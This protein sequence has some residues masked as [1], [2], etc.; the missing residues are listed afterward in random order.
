MFIESIDSERLKQLEYASFPGKIQVIDGVGADFNR[1][2]AYLRSQ[3]VIGF[4]TETRPCFSANQPRYGV[5]LL[6]LSGPEKAFLFRVNKMGMHRRLC[7]IL[8]DEKIVKV[9]AAIHD[10]I[11]GLQKLNDFKAGGFV[12]L[13]RIVWEWGIRDKSVKKM[14]AIIMGFRISKTQQLSN[15]EAETL[16][17]QQCKYAATDAWVC[18]EMYLK[19][20]KSDKHPLELEEK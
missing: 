9:G 17:E 10:D 3:K 6:Q 11:R 19:L 2:V 7:S 14:A 13:Q 15:W 18:R 5:A 20:M 1:A 12:D 4:D 8:A 16:S